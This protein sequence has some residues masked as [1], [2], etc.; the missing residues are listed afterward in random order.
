MFATIG[1]REWFRNLMNP[2]DFQ[3]KHPEDDVINTSNM[4]SDYI[5]SIREEGFTVW[6][7]QGESEGTCRLNLQ[8]PDGRRAVIS[9]RPD[10]IISAGDA[11]KGSFL[12]KTQCIVEIQSNDDDE[13]CEVQMMAYIY[14]FMNKMGL[15]KVVGFLIYRNGLVKA[16]RA[17]REPN[18][19]YEEN[20]T[21][22]ISHI[23]NVLA[24]VVNI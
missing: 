1:L 17:S 24:Q 7:T 8:T 5:P 16:Y 22:H 12:L 9:G 20:D 14:I 4:F 18:I 13:Q 6:D 2:I 19:V 23:R 10:F 11:T 3:F 15:K 21:F